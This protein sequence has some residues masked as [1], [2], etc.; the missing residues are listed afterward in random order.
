[1]KA[2]LEEGEDDRSLAEHFKGKGN[3][4]FAKG[5][6]VQLFKFFC[7]SILPCI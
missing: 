2:L 3:E 1:M 4:S 7:M 6:K 5:K